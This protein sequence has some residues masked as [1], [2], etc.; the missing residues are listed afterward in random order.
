[1]VQ[2]EDRI[3]AALKKNCIQ[4]P[5]ATWMVPCGVNS[6]DLMIRLCTKGVSRAPNP[7]RTHA[8]EGRLAEGSQ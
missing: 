6:S 5:T 8:H 1:M 3:K 7:S 4:P 2:P